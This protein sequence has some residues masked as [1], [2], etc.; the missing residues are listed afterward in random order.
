MG[1]YSASE[2]NYSQTSGTVNIN[3]NGNCGGVSVIN[4]YELVCCG[5]P[6]SPCT[7]LFI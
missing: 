5:S 2:S 6:R 7:F 3:N 4:G 1:C